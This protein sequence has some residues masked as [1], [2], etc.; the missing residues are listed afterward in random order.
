MFGEGSVLLNDASVAFT[1]SL[2]GVVRFDMPVLDL[3][4]DVITVW[5]TSV[6][7]G[8]VIGVAFDAVIAVDKHVDNLVVV[9]GLVPGVGQRGWVGIAAAK[10]NDSSSFIA[11]LVTM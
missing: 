8:P 1:L 9:V 6:V 5:D 3:L 2:A 4:C 11:M 7:D 10:R